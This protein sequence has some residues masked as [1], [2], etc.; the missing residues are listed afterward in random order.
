MAAV[1]CALA[2]IQAAAAAAAS[3]PYCTGSYG[4]AAPRQAAAGLRFG[5]DPGIAGSAGGVQLPSVPDDPARDQAAVQALAPPGRAMVVRLNR[6]FWSDGQ[7]GIDSFKTQVARY[8]RAGFE[9]E[10]QVRYHPAQGQAGNLA[11]WVAYVRHVV[12]T[13]G[14]N[15][16]VVSMTITNEV[17]VNFSPNTSDGYYSGAEDALIQGIEAAHAEALR[18]GFR[19]LRFGFTYAYRFSPQG[20]AAFFSYLAAHGGPSFERALG[21]VGVDFYPGAVYPP[22]MAPGESYRAELA[23]AAGVVRDC[24][25]PMAQIPG[26]VPIWFTENGVSTG[27]LSEA[28]QAAAL[29][30]LTRAACAYSR[31]F[32]ITDYRWFNLRDSNSNP[33]ASL[34]APAFTSFGL[35]RDDY[36]AKPSFAAY[37][38][39]IAACGAKVA[40]APV[41]SPRR[42]HR[43]HR[44]RLRGHARAGTPARRRPLAL[45][46]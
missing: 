22:A 45:T 30:E 16:R 37:R 18:M 44:H 5:I 14:P 46:G 33:P 27:T 29:T 9:A 40:L 26:T 38:A 10:I 25:L 20:D 42:R 19:Q 32:N 4:A 6:L 39:A 41:R 28:Q 12:D 35:L 34:I 36:S 13:F 24:Y 43:T 11:A 1:I 3:D 15:R 23:Q 8:T 2:G 31:T 21:F 7:A 17:N